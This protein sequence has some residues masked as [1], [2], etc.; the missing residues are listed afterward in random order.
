LFLE[1]DEN[2]CWTKDETW[3]F[4]MADEKVEFFKDR[5]PYKSYTNSDIKP[6]A[7]KKETNKSTGMFGFNAGAPSGIKLIIVSFCLSAHLIV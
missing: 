3:T 6:F 7:Y 2:T 5:S 1:E 4:K